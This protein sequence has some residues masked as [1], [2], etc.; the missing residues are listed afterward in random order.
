MWLLVHTVWTLLLLLLLDVAVH[1]AVHA[2]RLLAVVLWEAAAAIRL[3]LLPA[4]GGVAHIHS[5]VR[6]LS[7]AAAATALLALC[8]CVVLTGHWL[9]EGAVC[10]TWVRR[11][12][13]LRM[14]TE[15]GPW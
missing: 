3:L 14:M 1:T 11:W 2:C 4:V 10:A 9:L 15:S 7:A 8:V 12:Y 13:G 5:A 6:G